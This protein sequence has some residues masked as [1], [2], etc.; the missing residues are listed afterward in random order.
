MQYNSSAEAVETNVRWR[1]EIQPGTILFVVYTDARE[2]AGG[3]GD[4]REITG[5]LN[6]SI[7]VKFT[8]LFRF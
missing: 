8:R 4:Q 6:R 3:V 5:L 1:W 2:T 7:A